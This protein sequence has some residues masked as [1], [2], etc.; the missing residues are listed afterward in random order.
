LARFAAVRNKIKVQVVGKKG[1][2]K[3]R[4]GIRTFGCPLDP[5]KY[6][7]IKEHLQWCLVC[8]P[9]RYKKNW[10]KKIPTSAGLAHE[11]NWFWLS[12]FVHVAVAGKRCSIIAVQL[13]KKSVI[14]MI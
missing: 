7:L 1:H 3:G 5:A 2:W 13:Q 14:N 10:M 12:K 6:F 8:D 11:K 9:A 4:W